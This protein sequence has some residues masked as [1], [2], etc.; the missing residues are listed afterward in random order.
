MYGGR[1]GAGKGNAMKLYYDLHLHSCLSPCGDRDMTPANIA[2]MAKLAGLSVVAVSDH[3][4]TRNCRTFSECA[5]KHGL[6]PV[7]AIE[8]NTK[9][10]VHILCLLPSLAAAEDFDVFVYERLPDVKNRPD[11]FGEQLIVDACD[12]VI[13]QEER[14]LAGAVDISVYEI[15]SV[16]ERYGGLAIPAHIDRSSNSVVSNLGFVSKEMN[17][18]VAEVTRRGDVIALSAGNAALRG[19]PYI[20]NSDAHYLTDIPDAEYFLDMDDFT[21]KSVLNAIKNGFGLNLL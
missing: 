4:T 1:T 18:S 17:F 3:N 11:F 14:M 15:V 2:G 21:V 10:E 12:N 6:L 20:T 7:P 9:E 19:K 5:Q 8:V 13:G 16:L